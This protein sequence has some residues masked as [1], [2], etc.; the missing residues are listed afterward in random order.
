MSVIVDTNKAVSKPSDKK[1]KPKDTKKKD[2]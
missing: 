2:K 1:Q